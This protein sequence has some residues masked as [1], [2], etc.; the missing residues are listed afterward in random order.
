VIV[1]AALC[2]G[3]APAF[4]ASRR[5]VND[6]LRGGARQAGRRG[7]RLLEAVIV[8]QVALSLVLLAGATVLARSLRALW[9]V[10]TGFRSDGVLTMSVTIPDSRYKE[11]PAVRQYYDQLSERLAALPGV[12]SVGATSNLPLSGRNSTT[13]IDIE[14]SATTSPA[15]RPSVQRRVVRPGYFETMGIPLRAGRSLGAATAAVAADELV[16][17]EAMARRSWPNESALGKRLRVFG[18]W[19]TVV[20]VVGNVRHTRLDEGEEPTIYL[21]HARVATREMT[22]VLATGGDP[23]ALIEAVR[24]ATWSVDATVPIVDL[25]P[26]ASRVARSISAERYRTTLLGAFGLSAALLTAVG[27]FGVIAR[28]V[29]QRRR[30]IAIRLALGAAASSIARSV[31]GGQGR[32]VALGLALGVLGA[33]LVAPL[34]GRFVY[35]ISPS[36]PIA[37]VGALGL[38]ML[39]AGIAALPPIRRALRTD[40]GLALRQDR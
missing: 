39:V 31:V 25:E 2:F 23:R 29:S 16:V 6:A 40:P 12:R 34:L 5:A 9:T 22:L 15:E 30:E 33:R 14:G 10:D 26:M 24:R 28:A 38:M 36:D 8:A 27:V 11:A 37:L 18:A 4:S 3:L 1:S 20:G 17:D 21:P 19:L 13:T 35:G 7:P 32:S